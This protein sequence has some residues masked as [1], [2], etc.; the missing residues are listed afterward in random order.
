[1]DK[2]PTLDEL[3]Q[4]RKVL[5]L[6]IQNHPEML[7]GRR[8]IT[9]R[10]TGGGILMWIGI[11]LFCY[12]FFYIPSTYHCKYWFETDRPNSLIEC[13]STLFTTS[14]ALM[15]IGLTLNTIAY[16]VDCKYLMP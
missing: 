8:R 5:N 15:L 14:V 10:V 16:I 12:T 11:L 6:E 2:P 7:E 1:M 13:H 3:R 9:A 4:R